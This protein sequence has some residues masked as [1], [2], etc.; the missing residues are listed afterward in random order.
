MVVLL[1]LPAICLGVYLTDVTTA[2]ITINWITEQPADASIFVRD[3][4]G[5]IVF[6]SLNDSLSSL[7]SFRITGLAAGRN[8]T[9]GVHSFSKGFSFSRMGAFRT[10]PERGTSFVFAVYGDNRNNPRVHTE[11]VRGIARNDPSIVIN[12]GDMVY[13]DSHVDEWLEFFETISLLEEAVY[14]PV[15]GN[16]EKDAVNYMRFFNPPGNGRYYHFWY[17]DILF[18][19]LNSNERFDNYSEQYRWLR[20]TLER[21]TAKDPAFIFV[22]FHHTAYSFGFHGDHRYIKEYIVPVLEE[23]GVDVVLNGHDHAYQRIERGG[24]TY[25]VTAGGGAPLYSL[26]EGDDSLITAVRAYHFLVAHYSDG[27]LFFECID[28]EGQIIDSFTMSSRHSEV[29]HSLPAATY[30]Y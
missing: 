5:N 25:L 4:E 23:F 30:A 28:N 10:A 8:Y 24:I 14:F 7:H 12:T 19:V 17:S 6:S 11:I 15:I 29:A 1:V 20:S 9:Y 21:E 3:T 16:H 2:E 18:I 27:V 13:D 26:R 22:A